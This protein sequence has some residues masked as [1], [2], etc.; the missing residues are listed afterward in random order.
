MTVTGI[1]S[2]FKAKL[3]IEMLPCEKTE[4]MPVKMK[5]VI[6]VM[7]RPRVLGK[8]SQATCFKSALQNLLSLGAMLR[9]LR[10]GIWMAICR[11]APKATPQAR[12]ARPKNL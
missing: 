5:I 12:P 11:N 10:D 1:Y 2:K 8:E 6:C 9:F 4:A 7:E 3:K